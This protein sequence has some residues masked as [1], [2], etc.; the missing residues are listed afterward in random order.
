MRLAVLVLIEGVG[1][2]LLKGASITFYLLSLMNVVSMRR[3]HV[4]FKPCFMHFQNTLGG[5]KPHLSLVQQA[6]AVLG[7]C[8]WLIFGSCFLMTRMASYAANSEF[9]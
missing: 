7:V 6:Q 9:E 1:S 4:D 8:L 3:K 2:G 5:K